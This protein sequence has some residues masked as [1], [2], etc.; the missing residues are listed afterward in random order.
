M[1]K[2][3][4]PRLTDLFGIRMFVC[5]SVRRAISAANTAADGE[6]CGKRDWLLLVFR[7]VMFP[8]SDERVNYFNYFLKEEAEDRKK[9]FFSKY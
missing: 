2:T 6:R 8:V 1:E 9:R 3:T 7:C 4:E 5:S